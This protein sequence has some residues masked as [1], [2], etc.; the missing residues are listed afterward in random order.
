MMC[1]ITVRRDREIN[2]WHGT[3]PAGHTVV[4]LTA[5]VGPYV[6]GNDDDRDARMD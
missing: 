3:C 5:T 4:P 1:G 2:D 6:I